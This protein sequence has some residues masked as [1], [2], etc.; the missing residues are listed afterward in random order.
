MYGLQGTAELTALQE[1]QVDASTMQFID[2]E[3]SSFNY[4]G[5]DFAN[6]WCE[7]AGFEGDYSRYPDHKQQAKFVTGYLQQTGTTTPVSS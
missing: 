1:G 4:R 2:F 7:Y 6:H 5:F 3:Y